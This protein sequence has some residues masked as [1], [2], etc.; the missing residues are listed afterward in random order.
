MLESF[1]QDKNNYKTEENMENRFRTWL[2]NHESSSSEPE[3]DHRLFISECIWV[4]YGSW[5]V[6]FKGKLGPLIFFS[7]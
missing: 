6:R 2:Q 3:K 4:W 7:S 1:T 5:M